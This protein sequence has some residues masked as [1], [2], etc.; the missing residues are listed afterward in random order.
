MRVGAP[1]GLAAYYLASRFADFTEKH[2]GIT[3]QLVPVPQ[4]GPLSRREVDIA[5][6]LEKPEAGRFVARKLT[7]YAIG[8]FA[9]AGYL[10]HHPG[11]RRREDLAD[12]M[13]VGYV[14]E[15]NYSPALDY[16]TELCGSVPIRFQCA[17]AVGQ[18]EAVRAGVGIGA[19]HDFIARRHPELVHVLP[20]SGASRSY[21][22]VEHEDTRGIGRVRAV[23]DFLVEAEE[24][25]RGQFLGR[26]HSTS[27]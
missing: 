10:H 8:L 16:V 4:V 13:M 14:E 2:R 5:V 1:D 19:I 15:F 9:S 3:V 7:D 6:V 20:D 24:H 26:H 25:D 11:P 12:H 22:L 27:I 17:S 23:H 21:W 18:F